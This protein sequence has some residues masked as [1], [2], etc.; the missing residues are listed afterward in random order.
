MAVPSGLGG[1]RP[2]CTAQAT[3]APLVLPFWERY[4]AISREVVINME[5]VH[6]DFMIS[7]RFHDFME[8]S[9]D[10]MEIS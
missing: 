3:G 2:F 10:F 9:N 6:G 1:A 8:I 4:L 5:L 7:W